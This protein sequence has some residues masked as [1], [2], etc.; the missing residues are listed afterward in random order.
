MERVGLAP[1]LSKELSAFPTIRFVGLAIFS[2]QNRRASGRNGEQPALVPLQ[3]T[4]LRCVIE[5]CGTIVQLFRRRKR[6]DARRSSNSVATGYVGRIRISDLHRGRTM[7]DN[8]E[9][10]CSTLTVELANDE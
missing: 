6:V 9:V 2:P 1:D 7:E 4:R 5:S 3:Y 8:I 10:N